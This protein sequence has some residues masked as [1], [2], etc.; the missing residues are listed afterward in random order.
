[1]ERKLNIC[2]TICPLHM[3]SSAEKG[4]CSHATCFPCKNPLAFGN[5]KVQQRVLAALLCNLLLE[6]LRIC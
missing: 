5:F 4:H 6:Y 3:L 2:I 1:M